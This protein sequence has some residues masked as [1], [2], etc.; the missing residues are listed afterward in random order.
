MELIFQ[1]YEVMGQERV[2]NGSNVG[3]QTADVIIPDSLP[4]V[5]RIIEAYGI[6]VVEESRLLPGGLSLSGTVQGSVLFVGDKGDVYS[7]PIRIPFSVRKELPNE[8][9]NGA[10][11]YTFELETVD[12]R[13]VNSRKLLV[14]AGFRWSYEV[15]QSTV[16]KISYLEEPSAQ[17][18]LKWGE[19]PLC[20][21]TAH[22]EKQFTVN[23]EL[24]LPSSNPAVETILKSCCEL[25]VMEQKTV[26]GK[27]VFKTEV[28]LHV[29]YRDPQGKLCTYDWRIPLSQYADLSAQTAEGDL[30][31]ILHIT[32]FDLEPDST[33]GSHRLFLHVG[34]HSRCMA[35]EVR[36]VKVMEDAY[37]TDGLLEPQWQ[38][39]QCRALLDSQTLRGTARWTGN[40][41]MGTLVDAWAWAEEP[42]KEFRDDTLC[43]TV[44]LVCSVLFYD[45]EGQLRSRQI[46]C[47][48][49]TELPVNVGVECAVRDVKC[50]EVYCNMNSGNGELRIPVQLQADSYGSQDLRSLCGGEI[51][52]LP[53]ESERKPSVILRR[54]EGDEDLWAIAKSY[55]TPVRAIEEANDLGDGP[56][57]HGTMLL[58][59]M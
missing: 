41:A 20:I 39:W 51:S 27:G 32:E 29:L 18:Q 44:P 43:I 16:R 10:L 33:T 24:E 31:T 40:E 37:C 15:Y 28:F 1:E 49:E 57:P 9:E 42:L 46:R 58:I 48:S 4:D 50:S 45:K 13:T 19:Y 7:L 34:I 53:V 52:P 22:G 17:L 14:R 5:E 36:N 59:P 8:V 25:Q 6:P 30:K 2:Y 11:F 3:E 12:A 56:I 47:N 26:G 55:R 23:E 21:P 38:Q 54:T 35:Y